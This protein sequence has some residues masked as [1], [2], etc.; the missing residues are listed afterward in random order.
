M[1]WMMLATMAVC[2]ASA[3]TLVVPAGETLSV[4]SARVFAP[5]VLI[6]EGPGTLELPVNCVPEAGLDIREGAVCLTAVAESTLTASHLRFN[7]TASR[8][9]P[10]TPPDYG[11]SGVQFSEFRLFKDRK[12]I[13]LPPGTVAQ[14]D[15][16]SREGPQKALDGNLATKCYNKIP[17]IIH[18]PEPVTFDGYSFATANDAPGRD[19]YTWT[20]EAGAARKDGRISWLGVGA[21]T[22]FVAPAARKTD[23]DTI[24]PVQTT[25]ALPADCPVIL[26]GKGRLVLR[27]VSQRLE[28]CSGTGLVQLE[29]G[30][31]VV[32]GAGSAFT[33]SVAGAGLAVWEK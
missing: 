17:L 3:E 1:K 26:G 11:G 2:A 10:R 7:V 12:M 27:G 30:A 33:G 15:D 32:F 20:L 14:G 16:G 4:P 9:A 13:S 6:K 28:A 21:V 31:Q 23:V 18:F 5:D 22:A 25:A 19:P 8:P 24:F 29:A